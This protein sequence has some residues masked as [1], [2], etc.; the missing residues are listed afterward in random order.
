MDKANMGPF[1]NFL[2]GE[3]A[4]GR[5]SKS[6]PITHNGLPPSFLFPDPMEVVFEPTPYGGIPADAARVNDSR[7]CNHH[8]VLGAVGCGGLRQGL[9]A[10][11]LPEAYSG[12]G[13]GA[14]Q[15]Q[16]QTQRALRALPQDQA[17]V[18]GGFPNKALVGG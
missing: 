8:R 2:L 13:Q 14:L 15:I 18:G 7:S 11:L 6:I 4:Q 9:R 16:P 12:P 10:H 17:T 3:V 5:G 1:D